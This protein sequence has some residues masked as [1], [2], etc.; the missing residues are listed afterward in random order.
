MNG[1]RFSYG[2]NIDNGLCQFPGVVPY[3]IIGTYQII[4][5]WGHSQFLYV[6]YIRLHLISLFSGIPLGISLAVEDLV[7]SRGE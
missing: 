1:F 6:I 2:D 7:T 4:V 3:V 5:Y